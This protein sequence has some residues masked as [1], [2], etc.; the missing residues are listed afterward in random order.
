MDFQSL[1]DTYEMA[2]AVLSVEKT[3]DGHWG[4]I[5][6]V[7]ANAQYK[8]IMGPNYRDDML[9]SDL[10]P[11]ERNFED[12]CFRCA[13]Q[14]QHLHSYVDTKSMGLWTDAT[15]IPLS[16]EYDTEKLSYFMFYF[17]FTKAPDAKRLSNLSLETAPFVIQTCLNL[18]GAQNFYEAM[19]TVIADIQDIT[20]SFCSCIIMIDKERQ[21]YATL[22]AKFSEPN[23]TMAD[24]EPYLTPDVVFSWEDTLKD[25]DC[26]IVKDDFD[27]DNLAKKNPVWAKS[28]RSANVKS[29]ILAPLMQGQMMSGVLFITNFNVEQIVDLKDFIEI[30]AFFLSAE[31][32]NNDLMERLEYMSNIDTLTGVKN[33]NSMNTRVD[34]HVK[35]SFPVHTPYGV[36]FADLNG[37]KQCND[38]GGHEAGDQLLKNAANL[39]KKHFSE[40]EVY[41]SGGD[42]FVIIMPGCDKAEFDKQVEE[43]RK[44]TQADACVSFA[45]G[46]DWS[47]DG[48]ELRHCMHIA[49][50]AMYADKNEFYKQHPDKARN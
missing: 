35:N 7:R 30:T 3:P 6:I 26:I 42:E 50:E 28:L 39:L 45:I 2:A 40:Y 14:K 29:L 10:I 34:W 37:L 15:Y 13:V 43:L 47:D 23:V 19:N 8:N 48:K 31:I 33:R 24:F 38:S 44:D 22:C 25:T 27:M 17:E 5:R 20:Q 12:F 41:R 32:A 49:D 21:K 18:R 9:Y 1:V 46:A 36:I 16:K 11:K 4:E